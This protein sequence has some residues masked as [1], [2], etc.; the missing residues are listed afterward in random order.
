[1]DP[2]DHLR[3]LELPRI[4]RREPVLGQLVL[5]ALG[6][7]LSEQSVVVA[8]AVAVGRDLQ[9]RHAVH[10][11]GSKPP[12]TAVSE[13]SIGLDAAQRIEIDVELREGD[14]NGFGQAEVADAI[15]QQ[16][17]DQELQGEIVDALLALLVGGAGRVHPAVDDAVAH[18]EGGS[19]EP[20][21]RAR[22]LDV[23][24]HGIGE[25]VEDRL[26]KGGDLALSRPGAFCRP[27]GGLRLGAGASLLIQHDRILRLAD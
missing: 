1:M 4:A 18:G 14:A 11:T 16:S 24:A 20:V 21:V 26:L 13:G 3:P 8:D 9:G 12:K 6:Q 10:K 5:P 15:E 27:G 2:V 23:L 7:D 22:A 17:A 19:G 25:L